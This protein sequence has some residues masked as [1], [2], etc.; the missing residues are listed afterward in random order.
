MASEVRP[1]FQASVAREAIYSA[2]GGGRQKT[3]ALVL[4]DA[5]LAQALPTSDRVRFD[6]VYVGAGD[7]LV[8]GDWYDA[9]QVA[10][11]RVCV[12][13]GDVVGH[14]LGPSIIKSRL[15]QLTRMASLDCA[16][17]RNL[18]QKLNAMLCAE[19]FDGIV[20][21]FLG[22]LELQTGTLT[23]ANAGHPPPIVRRPDGTA[24]M[25]DTG[26]GPLGLEWSNYRVDQTVLLDPGSLLVMYTDGLT[27][28]RRNVLDGERRVCEAI[29]SDAVALA[30]NPADA[31]RRAVIPFGSHDDVAILTARIA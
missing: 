28:A 25:F 7:N 24:T 10:D 31:L 16:N 6:G 27:E 1:R 30:I 21:M 15:K 4:Q 18:M 9:H 29:A 5:L 2:H 13:I 19:D 8:G 14:G 22:Y 11:R 26:D 12:C 23:Y 17:P 3:A 20:T